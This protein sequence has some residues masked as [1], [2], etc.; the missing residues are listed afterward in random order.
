MTSS[1]IYNVDNA[2]NTMAMTDI[3]LSNST[4]L[5]D[6]TGL[7]DILQKNIG[8]LNTKSNGLSVA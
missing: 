5:S 2:N 6:N 8:E 7:R 1:H 4:S 3:D